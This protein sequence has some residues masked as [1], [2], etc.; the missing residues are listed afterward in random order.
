MTDEKLAIGRGSGGLPAERR[1]HLPGDKFDRAQD[2]RMRRV[3]RVHLHGQIG[4]ARQRPVSAPVLEAAQEHERRRLMAE[5]MRS[6]N[7]ALIKPDGFCHHIPHAH[8]PAS[9]A[10]AMAARILY[11]AGPPNCR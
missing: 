2:Q 9:F 3:D 6:G 1:R 8:S 11:A 5:A 7:L 10:A 4:A